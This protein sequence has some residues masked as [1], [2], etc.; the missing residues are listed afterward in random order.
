MRKL[1]TILFSPITMTCL[2]LAAGV[3]MAYATFIENDFGA[4]FARATIYEATWF[5]IILVLLGINLTGRIFEKKLYKKEKLTIF[6]FHF[7]IIIMLIGAAITR[8]ISYEGMMHI[9]EGNE[10]NI[11]ETS[12]KYIHISIL[13]NGNEIYHHSFRKDFNYDKRKF[14]KSIRTENSDDFYIKLTNYMPRAVRKVFENEDGKPVISF[15][16]AG[17]NDRRTFYLSQGE[18][19]EFQNLTVSFTNEATNADINFIMVQDSFFVQS[20]TP[21]LQSSMSDEKEESKL[22]YELPFETR[23]IY[24]INKIN[25]VAQELYASAIIAPFPVSNSADISAQPVLS[26]DVI[27]GEQQKN[28]AV[29]ANINGS[30]AEEKVQFDDKTI[31]I[32]YGNK[33]IK[34]PFK[35]HLDDFVIERYPGSH[36]P[37]SFSSYVKL[38]DEENNVAKPFHIYMNN[39]LKYK[40]FRFYQ[41][42][43][44]KDEQGSILSVNYDTMGTTITYIGYFFLTLGMILSLFNKKSFF[45]MVGR[46]TKNMAAISIL[47]FLPSLFNTVSADNIDE[48]MSGYATVDKKHADKFGELLVQDNKGRT[49]PIYTMASDLFRKISRKEKIYNLTSMQLYIELKLNPEYWQNVP[50]IKVANKDLQNVIGIK[51]NYASFSDFIESN[52]GYKLQKYVDQAYA[53]APGQRDKFDKELMKVDERVNITYYIFGSKFLKVFPIPGSE[54]TEWQTPENAYKMAQ[55]DEAVFLEN[56]MPLYLTELNNAKI[57]GNYNRAEEYLDAMIKFQNKYASY[58][59]PSP[60]ER[61]LEKTYYK[62]NAFKKLFPFYASIGVVFLI[63]LVYQIISGIKFHNSIFKLIY[64]LALIGFIIHTLWLA[65]RW[66]VSGHAPMSNGYES[67]IFISWVTMLA[68]FIYYKRTPFAL[69]STL[70]LASLTLMVANLSFMDPEITNLVPVL[71][72]YWLTIHVSVITASYGFLGLGFILGLINLIM[73]A[74]KRENNK[75]RIDDSV[76]DLTNLNHKTIIIGLYLLTIGTFLGA[77]WANESWGRYWGWD[78]KE[79]WSLITIIVY[80]IVSHARLV[81]GLKGIFIY[82]VL[83]LYA[84]S[85]VLMT[86][87]GVNYYLSGLHSYAGG[88]PVPVPTFVYYAIVTLVLITLVAYFNNNMHVMLDKK[89][90]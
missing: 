89:S 57:S 16:L 64:I 70:V 81:P 75:Q 33:K 79:T 78:P 72:S 49:E 14:S 90:E 8:Y 66:Y 39:I 27:A 13:E 71:K 67:M 2:L 9:R 88:D 77:V 65:L 23:K 87:F 85:S 46:K 24:Q 34:L 1:G 50:F 59:L 48:K 5:E 25:L 37:S 86:Y 29:W 51:S 80:T 43:Y 62:F 19:V 82:N 38:I 45:S 56:I 76:K 54:S 26:F 52:S 35:I 68:G 55:G 31:K 84:F 28:I 3:A 47:F 30:Y 6:V 18:T 10:S 60:T 17:S 4:A 36:S 69:S 74:L 63:L 83:S 73:F 53:K 7:A 12:E 58:D 32:G 22:H 15:L 42:S 40:G 41:S 11:I 21:I 20:K 61:K 44:D